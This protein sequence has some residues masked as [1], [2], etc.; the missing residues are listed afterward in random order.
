MPIYNVKCR[1][2]DKRVTDFIDTGISG[3]RWHVFNLAD[4]S[5][6]IRGFMMLLFLIWD[7]HTIKK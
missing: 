3:Y 6:F 1:L 7:Y 4:V 5:Q 2:C